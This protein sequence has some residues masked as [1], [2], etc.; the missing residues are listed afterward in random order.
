[1]TEFKAVPSRV[2]ST[3]CRDIEGGVASMVAT[4]ARWRVELKSSDKTLELE[5]DEKDGAG[6]MGTVVAGTR[7]GNESISDE[8]GVD[9]SSGTEGS[10]GDDDLG[11]G[12]PVG[13][14]CAASALTTASHPFSRV[15]ILSFNSSFSLSLALSRSS[16]TF[17]S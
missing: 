14:P 9:V 10:A 4:R 7:T 12:R 17:L 13:R 15:L 3:R 6:E 5:S 1:M 16:S 2:K 11:R 8:G